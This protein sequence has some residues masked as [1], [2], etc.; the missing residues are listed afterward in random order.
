MDVPLHETRCDERFAGDDPRK[1]YVVPKI[2]E[3][4]NVLGNPD[5]AIA[6]RRTALRFVVHLVGD[7]HQPLHVEDNG[8]RGG[9]DTQVR[10][11]TRGSNMPRVW[12]SGMLERAGTNED[13]W[14]AD[15]VALDTPEGSGRL[16]GGLGD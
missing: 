8:D 13:R 14:L 10:W 4:L 1:D 6:E 5:A 16:R 12:D 15:L 11:F 2:R 7:L 9:N 3:F